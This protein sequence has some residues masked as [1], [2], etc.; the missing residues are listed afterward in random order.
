MSGN[1]RYQ[2]LL[3]AVAAIT[4]LTAATIQQV[5]AAP[6]DAPNITEPRNAATGFA[7][8]LWMTQ[9]DALR[10]RCAKLGSPSDGEFR[11]ALTDWQ[12]RNAPY[13]NAALEYMAATEDFISAAQGE[14]ARKEFRAARAAEFAAATRKSE[15]VWFPDGRIDEASCR[16]MANFVANGSLDVNQNAEFFPILQ[17]MKA[18]TDQKRQP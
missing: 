13:V 9:V 14:T 16:Q 12:R 15:A 2:V 3:R 8:T 17:T 4:A 7:I 5:S 11:Q 10:D 18:E 6:A 1:S